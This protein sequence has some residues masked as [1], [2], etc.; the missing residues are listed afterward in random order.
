[1]TTKHLHTVVYGLG[2]GD[3]SK[4]ATVDWLCSTQPD[5]SAVVRFNGGAQ[6][7]H[8]VY[9]GDVHHTFHQFG[10]GTLAGIPTFLSSGV[11]I[12]PLALAEE[13]VRLQKIGVTSPL[14]TVIVDPD[15]LLVTPIHVAANMERERQ[16]GENPHGST[17]RGIGET[18]FYRL[19]TERHAQAGELVGDTLAPSTAHGVAPRVKH[20]TSHMEMVRI[21]D[22]MARFYA[23]LTE[24]FESV[25]A[26]ADALYEFTRAVTVEAALPRLAEQGP[27][28][29]E[30]GQGTLIDEYIGFHPHTT[31][32][33]TVP[34]GAINLLGPGEH[35]V[36]KLGVTRTYLTRH[37]H[38][39]FPTQADLH[40]AEPDGHD[41]DWE[42]AFRQGHFDF[43]LFTYALRQTKPDALAVT[44]TDYAGE[45]HCWAPS[46]KAL[47]DWLLEPKVRNDDALASQEQLT[48]RVS[49]VKTAKM[50]GVKPMDLLESCGVPILV[51]SDGPRRE[52]RKLAV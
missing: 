29:F 27:L 19:A 49:M 20:A 39:P 34:L 36:R 25:T 28:V 35:R 50:T 43:D 2:F 8:N 30:A 15:A 7:A 31:W 13:S 33:T 44:H 17:A 16:R 26:I 37:G 4:G 11:L 47:S 51:T 5:T 40:R 22:D 1:M 18:V 38:G 9:V 12:D 45:V 21:L 14:R 46:D 6:A 42:G 10:A 3:E 52:D 41:G 24:E 23:P 32:S 48:A